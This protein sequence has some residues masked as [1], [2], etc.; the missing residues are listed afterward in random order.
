MYIV[1]STRFF[2]INYIR[3][4]V[5]LARN[6]RNTKMFSCNYEDEVFSVLSLFKDDSLTRDVRYQLL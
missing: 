1:P 6:I 4:Y 2:N 5:V 3:L